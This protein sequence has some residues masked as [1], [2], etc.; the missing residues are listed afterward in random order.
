[1]AVLHKG[2]VE[3]DPKLVKETVLELLLGS[4][5][6]YFALRIVED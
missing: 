3:R 5:L 2:F 6:R 1:M 4:E